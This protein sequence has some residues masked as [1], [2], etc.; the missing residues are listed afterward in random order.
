MATDKTGSGA[1]TSAE[2]AAA[3]KAT[4]TRAAALRADDEN[5]TDEA[6]QE[7]AEA[8]VAAGRTVLHGTGQ[9]KR[10]YHAGETIT[11]PVDEIERLRGL[12]YLKPAEEPAKDPAP[13]SRS[14]ASVSVTNKEAT[15]TV[16]PKGAT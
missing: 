11:L 3:L 4:E 2:N 6:K 13:A 7:T 8:E 9:K 12:G 1:A 15:S 14:D 16:K 5:G 10:K